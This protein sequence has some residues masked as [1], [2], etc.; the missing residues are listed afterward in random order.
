MNQDYKLPPRKWYTLEQAIKRIKQLTGEEL[1]IADLIH[2]WYFKKIEIYAQIKISNE[3]IDVIG[4][5]DKFFKNTDIHFKEFNSKFENL[6]FE[7]ENFFD[8]R[9]INHNSIFYNGFFYIIPTVYNY[10]EIE[11][12]ILN[13]KGISLNLC[14]SLATPPNKKKERI[15]FQFKHNDFEY[16]KSTFITYENL[17]ILEKGIENLLY[18]NIESEIKKVSKE[19]NL[20]KIGRREKEIKPLILSI[21]KATFKQNPQQSR[22]KIATAIYKYIEEHYSDEYHLPDERTVINYLS[23]LDIGKAGAR[24]KEPVTIIDPFKHS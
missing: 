6:N 17:Y 24:N 5:N 22:N 18:K 21:A 23:D 7:I 3:Q 8:K 20:A 15:Y 16:S 4:I 12:F 2:Y 11:R 13:N 1:E 9:Y 10:A 19:Y 14:S